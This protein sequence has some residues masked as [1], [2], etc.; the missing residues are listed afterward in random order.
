MSLSSKYF[1]LDSIN[2][3]LPLSWNFPFS[4]LLAHLVQHRTGEPESG[5][6]VLYINL[7]KHNR[8]CQK[9][10]VNSCSRSATTVRVRQMGDIC[11]YACMRLGANEV[12][13]E[14]DS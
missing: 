5:N 3:T 2:I 9:S 4:F 1:E 7:C 8:K 11:D 6:S 14:L 13:E 12:P 10:F